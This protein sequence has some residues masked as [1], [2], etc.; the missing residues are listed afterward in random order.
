MSSSRTTGAVLTETPLVTTT[1]LEVPARKLSVLPTCAAALAVAGGLCFVGSAEASVEV[2]VKTSSY[3]ISGQNGAALLQAIALNGPGRGATAHFIAQTTYNVRLNFDLQKA[4]RS[5]HFANVSAVLTITY[6]YPEVSS[7][8]SAD[9][10]DRWNRFMSGVRKHEET[11]G[12]IAREMAAAAERQLN[13]LSSPGD[14]SCRKTRAEGKRRVA[15]VYA[16]YEARQNKFDR[17]EHA[18]GGNV[19]GLVSLLSW[20]RKL[21]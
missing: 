5:C 21:E 10:R 2:K 8:M 13:D 4:A 20:A 14:P 1:K 6:T 7:P 18:K 12:R 16:A 15:S 17:V 11:H 9:F 3:R 19:E